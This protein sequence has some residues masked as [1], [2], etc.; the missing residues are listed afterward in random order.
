[1]L[2][3]N[4]RLDEKAS[5]DM[6]VR[7]HGIGRQ[8]RVALLEHLVPPFW[9]HSTIRI[10]ICVM[11]ILTWRMNGAS[12][13]ARLNNQ[14]I[15]AR[16]FCLVNANCAS[17]WGGT[18]KN[19]SEEAFRRIL[20]LFGRPT[21]FSRLTQLQQSRH[22]SHQLMEIDILCFRQ[23]S[24]SSD[25][26]VKDVPKVTVLSSKSWTS[27]LGSEPNSLEGSGIKTYPKIVCTSWWCLRWKRTLN[28]SISKANKQIGWKYWL[29]VKSVFQGLS[30]R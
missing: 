10:K 9:S 28:V 23:F 26:K 24:Q 27:F 3:P 18:K 14:A 8:E 19:L 30:A 7:K 15:W 12:H 1:M 13:Q 2:N 29:Q 25:R 5:W 11:K 16:T 17:N 20:W 21:G 4:R 6:Y 22:Q